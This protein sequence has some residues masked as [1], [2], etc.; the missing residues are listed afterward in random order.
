MAMHEQGY[1]SAQTAEIVKKSIEE[2]AAVITRESLYWHR[3]FQNERK[4]DQTVTIH[5]QGAAH[6]NEP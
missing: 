6:S 4:S 5:G 3:H 1:T 2:A